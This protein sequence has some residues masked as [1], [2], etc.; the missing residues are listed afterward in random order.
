M[1]EPNVGVRIAVPG[2]A[3]DADPVHALRDL[4]VAAT[5]YRSALA[6]DLALGVNELTALE[7]LQRAEHTPKELV[8]LVGLSSGSI[9]GLLDRLEAAGFITRRRHPTDRRS[10]IITSTPAG[11]HAIGWV[12]DHTAAA[13]AAGLAGTAVAPGDLATALT[14]TA[15]ALSRDVAARTS[16]APTR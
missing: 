10:L 16:Q 11:R 6:A 14:S 7:Y 1:S 12:E 9:T 5:R 3:P 4:V 8:E 13:L 15:A 2:G